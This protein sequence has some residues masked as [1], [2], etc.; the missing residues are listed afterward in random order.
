MGISILIP[1]YSSP[2]A[3]ILTLILLVSLVAIY[4]F[5]FGIVFLSLMFIIVYV[6]AVLI[7]Y[8]YSLS[9]LRERL[10]GFSN[11]KLVIIYLFPIFFYFLFLIQFFLVDSFGNISFLF[12]GLNSF[13]LDSGLIG[14]DFV[15]YNIVFGKLN[16]I[17]IIA[18]LFYTQYIF[19]FIMCGLL[20]LVTLIGSIAI[21]TNI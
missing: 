13:A 9:M 16:E 2:G 21:L 4:L 7:L 18:V 6:G 3:V 10:Q 15:F 1:L 12:A 8:I 17:K 14:Q 20:L 19:L 5:N 11:N